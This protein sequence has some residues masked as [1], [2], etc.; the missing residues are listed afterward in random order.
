MDRV[1][2]SDHGSQDLTSEQTIANT[3]DAIN[4]L[5]S[6]PMANYHRTA[7]R[8]LIIHTMRNV[9]STTPFSMNGGEMRYNHDGA[10]QVAAFLLLGYA[11]K[12]WPDDYS[13]DHHLPGKEDGKEMRILLECYV[14]NM[15]E[16][17]DAEDA[18][19]EDPD[20]LIQHLR[21]RLQMDDVIDGP[22][23]VRET[24]S[25]PNLRD[26]G[27]HGSWTVDSSRDVVVR[28][29]RTRREWEEDE[30]QFQESRERMR[31]IE[32]RRRF[33]GYLP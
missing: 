8:S 30:Q 23:R 28:T 18:T 22:R 31:K 2:L 20:A 19:D 10:Q 7:F 9:M 32:R 4:A 33:D 14:I 15:L 21:R 5:L 24:E 17:G 29:A 27:G 25:V 6:E 1:Y 13:G 12:I 26:V 16:T 3:F 11:D